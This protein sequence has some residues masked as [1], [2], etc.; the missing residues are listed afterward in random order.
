M[1]RDVLA[2]AEMRQ[3]KAERRWPANANGRRSARTGRMGRDELLPH[4]AN[5]LMRR[6]VDVNPA[7]LIEPKERRFFV[8]ADALK[9]LIDRG[10]AIGEAVAV[11][12]PRMP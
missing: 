9:R 6:F 10:E 7:V 3:R 5:A 4:P 12:E 2:R 11:R 1:L 8:V